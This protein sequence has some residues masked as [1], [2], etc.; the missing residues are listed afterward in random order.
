MAE[1]I[2]PVSTSV[3]HIGRANKRLRLGYRERRPQAIE[4]IRQVGLVIPLFALYAGRREK[5]T[6]QTASL[7][8]NHSKKLIPSPKMI[9]VTGLKKV[10]SKHNTRAVPASWKIGQSCFR[11]PHLAI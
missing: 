8:L 4:S 6:Q 10:A 7:C 2:G 1:G 5:F 11:P 3:S 9:R